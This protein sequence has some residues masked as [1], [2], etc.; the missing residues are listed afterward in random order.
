MSLNARRQVQVFCRFVEKEN[1]IS[2]CVAK[3]EGGTA[4]KDKNILRH[5]QVSL[6]F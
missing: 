4:P 1:A 6:E 2:G 3:G 5:Y